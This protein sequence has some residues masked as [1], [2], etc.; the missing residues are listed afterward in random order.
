MLFASSKGQQ[1]NSNNTSSLCQYRSVSVKGTVPLNLPQARGWLRGVWPCSSSWNSTPRTSRR[2]AHRWKTRELAS[3]H[4]I[5][6][7]NAERSYQESLR[8]MM[9][10]LISKLGHRNRIPFGGRRGYWDQTTTR[11]F[12]SLLQEVPEVAKARGTC[13]EKRFLVPP[14]ICLI[15]LSLSLSLSLYIYIYVYNRVY[16]YI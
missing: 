12:P 6:Y 9:R 4:A 3:N 5:P 11:T 13:E 14:S 1:T 15:S 10:F 8:Q 2:R 7:L 16:I